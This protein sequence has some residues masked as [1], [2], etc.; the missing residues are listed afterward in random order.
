M[1]RKITR[2]AFAGKCGA[3]GAS[4][5]AEATLFAVAGVVVVAP[6]P[7]AHPRKRQPAKS[8]GKIPENVAPGEERC[9]VTAGMIMHIAASQLR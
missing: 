9:H 1:Q 5:L 3:F 7:V 4:G 2:L 8:T 6:L